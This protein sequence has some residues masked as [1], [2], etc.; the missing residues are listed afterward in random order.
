M[1]HGAIEGFNLMLK[2]DGETIHDLH[3]RIDDMGDYN[4]VTTAWHPTPA[5]VLRI[6]QGEPVY[7][8]LLMGEIKFPPMRV[9]VKT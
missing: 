2:G 9:G 5:E 4:E 3:A 8:T 6:V 1:Q 7:V